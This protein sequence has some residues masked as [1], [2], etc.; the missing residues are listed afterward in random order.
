MNRKS[1]AI[2]LGRI[3]M[4]SVAGSSWVQRRTGYGAI[5]PTACRSAWTTRSTCSARSSGYSPHGRAPSSMSASTSAKPC[6]KCYRSLAFLRRFRAAD[7]LLL[8]RRSVHPR[9]RARPCPDHRY[10]A[11]RRRR[12]SAAVLQPRLRRHGL[13]AGRRRGRWQAAQHEQNGGGAP[14]R[15]GPQ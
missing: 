14:R 6:S 3:S 12:L 11:F 4:N 10:G 13:A 2:H 7:R 15:R 8:P 5:A 9:Q 1:L